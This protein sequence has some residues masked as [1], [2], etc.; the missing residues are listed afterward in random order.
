MERRWIWF[1][2]ATA[3]WCA[4]IR[5]AAPVEGRCEH[6]HSEVTTTCLTELRICLVAGYCLTYS[7]C[8]LLRCAVPLVT[9]S[10]ILQSKEE[11]R[12]RPTSSTANTKLDFYH[13]P[14]LAHHLDLRLL[15]IRRT[16]VSSRSLDSQLL[17]L[18]L[19]VFVIVPPAT[20]RCAC[21]TT[22]PAHRQPLPMVAK[23]YQQTS[24]RST[25][26]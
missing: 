12:S 10:T 18:Q 2:V 13:S 15:H 25:M 6:A 16:N 5:L 17:S 4:D 26:I 22:S 7:L 11:S 19:S 3:N 8:S 23:C 20:T 9:L 21:V 1:G 14:P 24:Y